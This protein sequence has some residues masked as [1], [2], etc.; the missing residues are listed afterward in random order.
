MIISWNTTYE[1]NLA[2]R[3]CYRDAGAKRENE[4]S[5]YE[6]K[7]LLKEIALSGFKIVIF[8]GGEPLLREDIYELIAF[9]KGLGI[10]PVLGTN[11]TLIT[12][13]VARRL[14]EAGAERIGISLDSIDPELCDDFRQKKGV[15]DVVIEGIEN[16]K[17]VGLGFQIHTTVMDFNEQD[18]EKI[19]EMA[20]SLGASA[21]HIFFVLP[22]GRAKK[23]YEDAFKII[24]RRQGENDE[25]IL[26][27][28]LKE[29]VTKPT[30]VMFEGDFVSEDKILAQGYEKILQRILRKQKEVEIELRPICAP[31][32]VR[33]AKEMGL[34]MRFTKGCL[35]GISYCCILPQGELY[36]CPYLPLEV[37]NIRER[38]FSDLWR[39]S[40]VFHRLRSMDYTGRCGRCDYKSICGGCRARAFLKSNDYLAEDPGCFFNTSV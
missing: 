39:D 7:N 35:A 22:V 32:F 30:L 23:S 31:Q 3:H 29:S 14:K 18:L 36:P 34:E 2:C 11:G 1:C 16:L 4:L 28:M 17:G 38:R 37:G 25:G 6:G 21:H 5:T 9:A 40:E 20:V 19:T 13:D 8:S 27:S 24:T 33:I 12:R 26:N 10:R 15:Y